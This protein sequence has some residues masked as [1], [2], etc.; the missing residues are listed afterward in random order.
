VQL[1]ALVRAVP[2]SALAPPSGR[3]NLDALCDAIVRAAGSR[4]AVLS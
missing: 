4:T 3:A 1:G 2:V